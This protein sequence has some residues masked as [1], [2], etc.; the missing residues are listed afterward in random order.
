MSLSAQMMRGISVWQPLVQLTVQVRDVSW[1]PA[2]VYVRKAIAVA[3]LSPFLSQLERRLG[4]AQ[5]E[6]KRQAPAAE[7]NP[8][9]GKELG[10][11]DC[12]E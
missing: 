11:E 1:N 12:A 4:M 5:F 3:A 2:G 8:G 9:C 10:G 6:V 7:A